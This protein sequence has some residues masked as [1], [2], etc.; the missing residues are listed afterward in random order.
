MILGA[1]GMLDPSELYRCPDGYLFD[2]SVLRCL[3]EDTVECDKVPDLAQERFERPAITLR[4]ADLE[5]FFLRWS[6]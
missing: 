5:S 6:N 2:E 1:D 3:K 4:E